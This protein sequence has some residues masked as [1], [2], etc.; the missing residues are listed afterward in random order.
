MVTK[1]K[2]QS[3][4]TS[5]NIKYMYIYLDALHRLHNWGGLKPIWANPKL[6]IV[7]GKQKNTISVS[8]QEDRFWYGSIFHCILSKRGN[9]QLSIME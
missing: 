2:T 6:H 7:S 3:N 4:H 9:F 8:E 1:E 5:R